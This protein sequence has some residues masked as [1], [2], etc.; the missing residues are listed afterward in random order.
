MWMR[1]MKT[2]FKTPP[3][4]A[5]KRA[6]CELESVMT[7]L[8]YSEDELRAD[9][10]A[11]ASEVRRV[12]KTHG[13]KNVMNLLN[14]SR[15]KR[16]RLATVMK[17]RLTLQ[18]QHD[19][20]SSIELNQKVMTSVKQTSTALKEL[21]LDT[22]LHDIDETMLDLKESHDDMSSITEALQ[23]NFTGSDVSDNDLERELAILMEED[24]DPAFVS[25]QDERLVAGKRVTG[26]PAAHAN[27]RRQAS[28][29]PT[30]ELAEAKEDAN[31]SPVAAV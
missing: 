20:L 8:Q 12:Q 11:I 10:R 7:S 2:C 17:Q 21:G 24:C 19:A 23:Q 28:V 25:L 14:S 22:Q 4:E 9:I 18:N 6:K 27:E 13:S 30:T 16:I 26:E 29:S 1:V 3:D 31:A 5:R 15:Q